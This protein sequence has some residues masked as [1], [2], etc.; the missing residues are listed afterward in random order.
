MVYWI[1]FCRIIL[2]LLFGNSIL[3]N[4]NIGSLPN[5]YRKIESKLMQR[6]MNDHRIISLTI[7][8]SDK[9]EFEFL[10]NQ[11]DIDSIS[12]LDQFSTDE[13]YRFLNNIYNIQ[14]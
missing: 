11:S 6:L 2:I 8:Y 12:E 7:T 9:T 13:L 1:I 4:F 5:S 14:E 10:N 3:I